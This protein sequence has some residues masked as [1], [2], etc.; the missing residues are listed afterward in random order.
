MNSKN[1]AKENLHSLLDVRR[2]I[3]KGQEKAEVLHYF[4]VSVFNNQ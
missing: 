3:G 2:N 4:L 1:I